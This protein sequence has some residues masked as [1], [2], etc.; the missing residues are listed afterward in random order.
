MRITRLEIDQQTARLTID[1]QY[2]RL[3]VEHPHRRMKIE[4]Q[5]PEM[6]VERETPE[7]LLDLRGLKSN[8]GLKTYDQLISD[9]ADKAKNHALSAVRDTVNKSKF[10]ADITVGGNRIGQAAKSEMLTAVEPDMGHSRVP[11]GTVK[12]DGD[13]GSLQ[14]QWSGYDLSIDWEGELG[15]EIYVEPP[16][17][18][19]VDIARE[20]YIRISVSEIDIPNPAGRAIN[21]EV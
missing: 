19:E 12:M 2:A 4:S 1:I 16:Y 18:V 5:S 10:L 20:P 6:T 8:T 17:S 13:P 14:I 7:V 11:P 21:A 9:A 3:H 15:P